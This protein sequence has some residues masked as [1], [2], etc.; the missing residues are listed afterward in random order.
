MTEDDGRIR[1]PEPQSHEDVD[2][3]PG[4]HGF[5]T[6]TETFHLGY[7]QCETLEVRTIPHSC[8]CTVT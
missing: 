7:Q 5:S 4:N 1:T 8:G 6:P 2:H 3:V